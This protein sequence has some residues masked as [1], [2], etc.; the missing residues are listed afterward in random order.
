M[1][2]ENSPSNP[3]RSSR[4]P[5]T[6]PILVT[7]LKGKHFSEVCQTLVVNAHGCAILSPVKFDA[8][9]P[10]HFH[11]KEGRE[12][13]AHVVS[14][15]P[16]GS[17]SRNWRLGTRLDRPENFWGLRDHPKDWAISE[18]VSSVAAGPVPAD[19]S[20]RRE[21]LLDRVTRELEMQ[22]K[23][24][25]AE[26]VLPLQDEITHLKEKLAR[27]QSNPSRFEVSLSSIPPELETQLESRLRKGLSPQIMEEASRQS[28]QL[29]AAADATINQRTTEAY[30]NFMRRVGE[31]LKIVERRAR[32]T[33]VHISE[34]AEQHFRRGLQNLQQQL[35][36]G[37]NS[38]KRLSEELVHYLKETLENEHNARRGDLE[39]LRSSLESESARMRAYID[40][41][42]SRTAKLDESVRG[43]ESGLDQRL[44]QMASNTL[45][46]ARNQLEGVANKVHEELAARSVKVLANQLDETSGN[47]KIIQKGILASVSESLKSQASEALQA[48][49]QST[50]ELARLSVER[51]R[52]R[53]TRALNAAVRSV[54]EEF[55]AEVETGDDARK[56]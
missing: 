15:Q 45:K 16:V 18:L 31:E 8:G 7:S 54:S 9:V 23:K 2:I 38:L 21:V 6:I 35:L 24:A 10:L 12:A 42:D 39:K 50:T 19:M 48:F 32:E 25:I 1:Q 33:S 41:L 47:M 46:D 17:D 37:G 52:E 13:T 53:L 5:T 34:S 14:C 56:R 27:R 22:V 36:D 4:V 29:L 43:L 26:S 3:R 20:Q 11:S 55:Q 30:D 28:A 40:S 49:E 51:C 44:S